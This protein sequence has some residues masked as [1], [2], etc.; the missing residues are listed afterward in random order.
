MIAVDIGPHP[1]APDYYIRMGKP[2]DWDEADC[3][4]LAVR[5]VAATDDILFEP[6]VRIVRTDLPSGETFY[7]AFMSEWLPSEEDRIKIA[8]GQPIRMLVSGNGLPPVALWVR[9]EDE[10]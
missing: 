2:E 4:T 10:A 8:A 7:P 3:G 9:D 6:A 5:R 1:D